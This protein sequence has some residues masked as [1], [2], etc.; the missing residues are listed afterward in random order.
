MRLEKLN[1]KSGLVLVLASLW[2]FT[3]LA[4]MGF[5]IWV[6]HAHIEPQNQIVTSLLGVLIGTAFGSVNGALFT[7]MTGEVPSQDNSSV[8]TTKTSIVT[9]VASPPVVTKL[10]K[11]AM[12]ASGATVV[13]KNESFDA[14]T[15]NLL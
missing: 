2:I 7:S 6:L 9:P 15:E 11:V 13:A 1:S 8:T 12:N 14:S 5:G 10:E 3:L 4:I